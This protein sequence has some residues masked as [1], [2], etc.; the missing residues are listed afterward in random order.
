MTT[1]GGQPCDSFSSRIHNLKPL[2]LRILFPH[3]L[4]FISNGRRLSENRPENCTRPVQTSSVLNRR[5]P[6]SNGDRLDKEGDYTPKSGTSP[7]SSSSSASV[8]S[9]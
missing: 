6:E 3:V 4:P 7:L 1:A 8:F 9:V 5:S 2:F